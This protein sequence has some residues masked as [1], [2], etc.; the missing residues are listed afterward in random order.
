MAKNVRSKF[1]IDT[2]VMAA[3]IFPFAT[4]C[5]IAA[6]PVLAE[7]LPL[8]EYLAS[9]DRTEVSF[10]GR[11]RYD[12]SEGNFTFYNESR[13]PFGVSLDAGRDARERIERECDNPGFMV[14]YSDLCVI[15]GNGTVEIRGSR[16]FISIE[17]VDQLR[18]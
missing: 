17:S 4:F 18:K 10:T 6:G 1:G 14:S 2:S 16:V 3:K 8:S 13:E 12:S 11:I 5:A 9:M 15:S 7:T